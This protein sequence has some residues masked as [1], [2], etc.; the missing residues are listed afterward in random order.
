MTVFL[1][2]A[3]PDNHEALGCD[4]GNAVKDRPHT[5]KSRLLR[6]VQRKHVETV[7]GDIVRGRRKSHNKKHC[8]SVTDKIMRGQCERNAGKRTTDRQLHGD[9]P[10]TFRAEQI[11]KRAP[12]WFDNP[13]QIKPACVKGDLCVGKAKIFVKHDAYRHGNHVGNTFGEEKR[14][15]PKPGA[16]QLRGSCFPREKSHAHPLI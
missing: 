8:Q 11:D 5:D 13:G 6:R 9:Y 4:S 12:Q 16:C 10:K 15:H 2:K 14:R 3:S 7:G 1:K